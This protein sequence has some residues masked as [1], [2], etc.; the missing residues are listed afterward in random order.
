MGA[1]AKEIQNKKAECAV[2]EQSSG[3][4]CQGRTIDKFSPAE[5]LARHIRL[6]YFV[7]L[8][9]TIPLS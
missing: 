2:L 4:I 1:W 6:F 7:F 5:V 3:R 9:P 8:L